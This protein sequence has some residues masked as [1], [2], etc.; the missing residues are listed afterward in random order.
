MRL[1]C[2]TEKQYD[3]MKLLVGSRQT[4]ETAIGTEKADYYM[5]VEITE[6][7]KNDFALNYALLRNC[8]V[9]MFVIKTIFLNR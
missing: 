8:V 3:D 2:V 7:E 5:N 1:L 6:F 4:S 9:K